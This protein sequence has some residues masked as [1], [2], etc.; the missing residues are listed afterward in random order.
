MIKKY[1]NKTVF[2]SPTFKLRA[3]LNH[4][5]WLKEERKI[6]IFVSSGIKNKIVIRKKNLNLLDLKVESSVKS[7]F[8]LAEPLA[9]DKYLDFSVHYCN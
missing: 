1:A 5:V 7:N 2:V 3:K 4:V 9:V 8:Q 6:T